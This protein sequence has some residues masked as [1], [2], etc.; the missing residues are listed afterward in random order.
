MKQKP[1]LTSVFAFAL[2]ISCVLGCGKTGNLAS[3]APANV[4]NAAPGPTTTPDIAGQY[5]VAGTNEDGSPYKGELEVLRHGDVY[6]FRW[7]AGKQYDG[8]GIPN[9]NVVAVAFTGGSVGK[10]CGVVTYH[11]QADGNLDGKWG[12]WGVNESGTEKGTRTSGSDLAGD[13]NTNGTNPNGAT[14]KGRLTIAHQAGGYSFV[15][16]NNTSGFGVRQGDAVSVGIGGSRCAFVSYE[17]KP[18]G[19]LDGIWGGYGSSKT[20][21]EK[22]TKK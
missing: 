16:S 2:V 18:D 12:Y 7:N 11:V 10:G 5:T 13:Y 8:I 4:N 21:T 19:M 6:Q 3:P 22:A 20:G 1:W 17:I 9:G 15:W 14:Y